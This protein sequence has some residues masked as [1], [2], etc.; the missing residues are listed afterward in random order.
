MFWLADRL[1]TPMKPPPIETN[2]HRPPKLPK[3]NGTHEPMWTPPGPAF[4]D[5]PD[6][7]PKFVSAQNFHVDTRLISL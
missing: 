5:M 7:S 3:T 1:P 6:I 4:E 2:G